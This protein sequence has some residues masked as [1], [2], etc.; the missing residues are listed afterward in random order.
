MLGLTRVGRC[1][2]PGSAS[3]LDFNGSE[4]VDLS[5]QINNLTLPVTVVLESEMILICWRVLY[6]QIAMIPNGYAGFWLRL[7]NT[8][9]VTAYG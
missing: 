7:N 5:T 9:A 3:A 2:T 1:Q 6:S 4:Y 8:V